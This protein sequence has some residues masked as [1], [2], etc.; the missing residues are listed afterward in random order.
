MVMTTQLSKYEARKQ[1]GVAEYNWRRKQKFH[2]ESLVVISDGFAIAFGF[3][4]VMA[5][6]KGDSSFITLGVISMA[7][8]TSLFIGQ[9]L[10]E[11]A[12]SFFVSDK[13][14]RFMTNVLDF[15]SKNQ[16]L[17]SVGSNPERKER[18]MKYVIRRAVFGLVA[19]PLVAGAYVF[20]YLVLASLANNN[21]LTLDEV[22]NN[23]LLIGSVSAVAFAFATQIDR[24]VSKIIA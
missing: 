9:T 24:F 14:K 1:R 4:L 13:S 11:T 7:L 23:G 16:Y 21:P 18:Q 8:A 20:G 17:R 6:I 12:N 19:L 22:W 10:S 3:W 5:L 15:L 2:Y